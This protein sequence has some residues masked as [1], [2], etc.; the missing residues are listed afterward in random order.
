MIDYSAE[1]SNQ[2]K[3]T[4]PICPDCGHELQIIIQEQLVAPFKVYLALNCTSECRNQFCKDHS[5][6]T[7][8]LPQGI[9][10]C[11]LDTGLLS[12]E[13]F[14]VH[15]SDVEANKLVLGGYYHG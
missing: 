5:V 12:N 9:P 8:Y 10:K 3:D 4:N 1:L 11:R 2:L 7:S 6:N 14:F 13:R 15:G